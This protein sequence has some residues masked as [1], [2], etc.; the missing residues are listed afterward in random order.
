MS[1]YDVQPGDVVNVDIIKKGYWT[2][3]KTGRVVRLTKTGRITIQFGGD[4]IKT[5]KAAQ[6]T[7]KD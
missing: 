1:I 6:V 3:M 4:E 5:F 7:K 2:D